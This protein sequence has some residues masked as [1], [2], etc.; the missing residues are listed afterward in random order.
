MKSAFHTF[1]NST[2][3]RNILYIS[4]PSEETI[5]QTRLLICP[6]SP[7]RTR[8]CSSLQPSGS[9][10]RS[11][12]PRLQAAPLTQTCLQERWLPASSMYSS[13]DSSSPCFLSYLCC[14]SKPFLSHSLWLCRG[15]TRLTLHMSRRATAMPAEGV[16]LP[17]PLWYS[18]PHPFYHRPIL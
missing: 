12:F 3:R 2:S 1:N 17:V 16:R 9:P 15:E 8:T 13:P 4:F 6:R 5:R 11:P 7:M 14:A 18:L 10:L